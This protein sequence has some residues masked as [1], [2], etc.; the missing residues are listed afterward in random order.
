MHVA[1]QNLGVGFIKF[2]K[3]GNDSAEGF[4]SLSRL[5]ITDVLAEKHL[6]PNSQGNG[7]LEMGADGE[8]VSRLLTAVPNADG[9]RR[10]TAR[11]P[12]DLLPP[13][14]HSSEGII[15]VAHN[16]PVMHQ[17]Q[18]SNAGEPFESLVLIGANWFV[19]QIAAG[20]DYGKLKS[21][22]E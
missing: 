13:Q 19:A 20:R 14:Q 5:E 1:S 11:P 12:Q 6:W 17:E 4:E 7:V 16:W 10:V 8:K 15:H 2:L 21:V 9:Q 22:Q 18:V 3:I